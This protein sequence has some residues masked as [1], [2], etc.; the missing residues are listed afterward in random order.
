MQVAPT[1]L[2]EI[3]PRFQRALQLRVT[4]PVPLPDRQALE[5]DQG[6]VTPRPQARRRIGE[7]SNEVAVLSIKVS[8]RH[9][10][11]P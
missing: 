2:H 1:E 10:V 5:Q 9:S 8:S 3:R 11:A 6:I 4:R 7:A